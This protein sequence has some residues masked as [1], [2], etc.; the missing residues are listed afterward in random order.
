VNG[1][2]RF[3]ISQVLQFLGLVV[4]GLLAWGNLKGDMR[5][6]RAEVAGRLNDHEHRIVTLEHHRNR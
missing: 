6:M 1:Q 5:E 3:T 4:A 2:V